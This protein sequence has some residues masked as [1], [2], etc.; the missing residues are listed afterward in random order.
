MAVRSM[1]PGTVLVRARFVGAVA[2]GRRNAL[3]NGWK[4][5]R[6]TKLQANKHQSD[7]TTLA[8]DRPEKFYVAYSGEPTSASDVLHKSVTSPLIRPFNGPPP[9]SKP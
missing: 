8:H 7:P 5:L 3:H 4:H 6:R 9:R 2:L 1:L